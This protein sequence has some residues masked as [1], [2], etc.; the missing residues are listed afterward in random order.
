MILI[1]EESVGGRRSSDLGGTVALQLPERC[2][3]RGCSCIGRRTVNETT[4][5]LTSES[6]IYSRCP[7]SEQ[8][9]VV[10]EG[11]SMQCN[12]NELAFTPEFGMDEVGGHLLT[13]TGVA[14]VARYKRCKTQERRCFA[15]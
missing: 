6:M 1:V 8:L 10:V 15:F 13:L 11:A 4:S 9:L 14:C 5:L 12:S 7:L 3:R 2:L